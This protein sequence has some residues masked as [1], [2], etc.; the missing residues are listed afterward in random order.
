[1]TCAKSSELAKR[2]PISC[3]MRGKSLAGKSDEPTA[4]QNL[5][6]SD[7]FW[8]IMLKITRHD[9][10]NDIENELCTLAFRKEDV[11]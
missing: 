1:M 8:K 6:L 4:Y 9:V 7:I 2:L 3:S 10:Y 11:H 5:K